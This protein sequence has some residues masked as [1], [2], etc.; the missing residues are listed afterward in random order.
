MAAYLFTLV[1]MTHV[2]ENFFLYAAKSKELQAKHGG[3]YIIH[4]SPVGEVSPPF[5]GM[6]MVGLEFPSVEALE[7]YRADA[8]EIIPLREGTGEFY[9]AGYSDELVFGG[10]RSSSPAATER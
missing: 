5:E 8:A 7:A 6:T 1:K 3:R 4:N 10:A 2:N 9:S